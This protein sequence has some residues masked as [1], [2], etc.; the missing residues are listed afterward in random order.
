MDGITDSVD[1]SLSSGRRRRTGEPGVLPSL[2]SHRAGQA[3]QRR[4]RQ[5]GRT[6]SRFWLLQRCCSERLCAGLPGHAWIHFSLVSAWVRSCWIRWQF[7]LT[8]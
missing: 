6:C 7:C 4:A 1:V 5:S 2:G 8:F 3:E